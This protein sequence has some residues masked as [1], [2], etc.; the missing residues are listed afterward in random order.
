[1]QMGDH[2]PRTGCRTA[3]L[4]LIPCATLAA[5]AIAGPPPKSLYGKS[6][7]VTW[8]EQRVQRN[9]GQGEFRNLT[10]RGQFSA[11]VSSAG[12]LF[13]RV[14]MQNPR[15]SSGDR[16][17]VGNTGGRNASFDGNQMV[18]VQTSAGG[19]RQIVVTFSGGHS[20]CSAQVIFG[21]QQGRGSMV[22]TS[23]IRPN[24]KV[25]IKSV[26]STGVSCQV[27]DGNVFGE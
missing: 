17:R 3:L 16:D 12:R 9:D 1:M 14:T 11:Y 26:T 27:R 7:V 2:M 13:N 6:V 24:L 19:A 5:P 8:S 20:S 21:V 15:G 23:M 10:F 4:V 18:A 22:A 25:E